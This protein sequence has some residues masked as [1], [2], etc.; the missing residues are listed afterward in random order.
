MNRLACHKCKTKK[1]AH[2]HHVIYEQELDRRG[3]PKHDR[4]NLMGLCPGCHWNHHHGPYANKIPL[5]LLTDENL[6]YAFESLGAFAYDYLKRRY[7]GDDGRL[8][9]ML[10]EAA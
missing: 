2:R 4:R 9:E 6:Q 3:L 1:S 5:G 10:E 7:A 8:D